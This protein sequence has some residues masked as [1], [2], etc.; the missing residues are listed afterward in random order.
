MSESMR[1]SALLV[2]FVDAG[3]VDLVRQVGYSARMAPPWAALQ[4][5]RE[6]ECDILIVR[7]TGAFRDVYELID[8]A[9]AEGVPMSGHGVLARGSHAR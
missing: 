8:S 9:R 4:A 6:H 7:L 1:G 2:G 5:I 3:P